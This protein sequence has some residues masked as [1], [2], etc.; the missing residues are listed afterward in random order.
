LTVFAD[1]ALDFEARAEKKLAA[2]RERHKTELAELIQ[3]WNER[4]DAVERRE[5]HAA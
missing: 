1:W 2:I 3:G 5:N 4:L